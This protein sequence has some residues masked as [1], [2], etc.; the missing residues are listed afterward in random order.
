MR[1]PSSPGSSEFV[2]ADSAESAAR[3]QDRRTRICRPLLR[4]R[5]SRP[6]STARDRT[7]TGRR[8][9]GR[10]RFRCAVGEVLCDRYRRRDPAHVRVAEGPTPAACPADV[11]PLRTL[12]HQVKQLDESLQ[13]LRSFRFD[14][15]PLPTFD[16]PVLAMQ[17]ALDQ[18]EPT[19]GGA[20]YLARLAPVREQARAALADYEA[21]RPGAAEAVIRAAEA[22]DRFREESIRSRG[23]DRLCAASVV[24]PHQRRRPLRHRRPRTGEPRRLRS[25]RPDEPPRVIYDDPDVRLGL[26]GEPVLR[27]P[28]GLLRR[29]APGVTGRLAHLRDRRRRHE[30]AADHRTATAAT[31]P[32]SNCPAA[33]SCSSPTGPGTITSARPTAAG[34]LYVCERDGSQRAPRSAPTRSPITRRR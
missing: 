3:P 7:R 31:S 26:A 33:S 22:L 19:P 32:R 21:G 4:A 17:Q 30:P 20:A 5:F 6:P 2:I 18:L 1:W 24:R 13:K 12:Y 8:D 29:P 10:R 23:T 11:A 25:R 14:V 9:L 16:P 15:E 27:R 34:A 28:D